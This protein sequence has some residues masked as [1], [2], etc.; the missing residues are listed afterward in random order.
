MLA[1]RLLSAL[2]G[3]PVLVALVVWGP[4]WLFALVVLLVAAGA[5]L[6]LYDMFADA[7]VEADR[8][9]GLLLGALVVLAFASGRPALL[10]L[11]LSLAVI[12]V[13]ALGLRRDAGVD[14]AWGGVTLTLLGVC[15]CAWL[16]GHAIWLR[17]LPGGRILTLFALGVTWCGESA[18]FFVG[19]RFGRRPL[20]PRVSP[21]KTVEGGAAQMVVSV[22]AAVLGAPLVQLSLPE[23][24]AVGALLGAVGQ[25]GDLSESFLKRSAGAKD[26]GRIIPG[27]GG[28][29]DRLDS[30]LFNVPALYYWLY[31]TG[32]R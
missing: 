27:H 6:E 18:A 12:V 24:A 2:V 1:Q 32:A 9:A 22:L 10:P 17:A 31:F 11:A 16:L 30:L 7:G 4:A 5:Q 3:I 13:V 23:A 15:Y 20:A 19:R 21:G 29:L 26:A 25:V 28:L 14:R 8:A